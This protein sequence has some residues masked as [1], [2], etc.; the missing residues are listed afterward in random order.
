[1]DRPSRA[2]RHLPG[3]ERPLLSIRLSRRIQP[4]GGSF[5]QQ[6]GSLLD[7]ALDGGTAAEPGSSCGG[8]EEFADFL[9]TIVP[10][11]EAG[12]E[13]S[14]WYQHYE[15]LST[16]TGEPWVLGRGAMGITY[17]ARDT[18]LHCEVAL[19]VINPRYLS[20]PTARD[21]FLR[22]ARAAAGLRHPNIASIYHLGFRGD[23]AF[24]AM[25]YIAGVTLAEH[26]KRHG[27]LEAGAALDVAGQIALALA[28][29]HRKGFL[30]RDIKPTNLMLVGGEEETPGRP[31][32]KVID[33]GLVTG[34]AGGEI[35]EEDFAA[36]RYFVGTPSFA[37]PEQLA[38]RPLD[39][40]ADLYSL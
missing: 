32:V 25:E 20:D 34:L 11:P 3:P 4:G 35:L 29:A 30:H 19:K 31:V 13:N 17:K 1:M 16:P 2:S 39:A 12:A 28:A 22:E 23:D 8:D 24:Y 14:H 27:P 40:R 7:L 38:R 37:S 9:D 10:A 33:F 36:V 6:A 26:V 21:R 5:H 15:V 18:N